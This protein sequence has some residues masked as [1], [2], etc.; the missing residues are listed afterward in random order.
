[1]SS[2]LAQHIKNTPLADTHEHLRSEQE[3]VENSPDILQSL[4]DNYVASD[5]AVA[6]A[7]IAAVHALIDGSDPDLR[8]RFAGVEAAWP[9]VAHTGFGEA[10]R[11]AARELYDIEEINIDTL[12]AAQPR[13]KFLCRPGQR[14]RLLRERANLD[15]VQIDDFT[16]ACL[17]DISGPDF[18]LFDISWNELCKGLPDVQL[19]AG[20]TGIE[21]RD[22]ASLQAVMESI[23]DQHAAI[24]VAVKA[25]HAYERTLS[26]Q[27]R[28]EE[29]AAEALA[30]YLCDPGG[31]SE[32]VRLCLG[33]WCWARGVELAIE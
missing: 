32:A 19:L 23:F 2:D 26:W 27:E 16:V 7:P 21:I 10:V 12:E 5:L 25:Q 1:M 31:S 4:F 15:H 14:L 13:H 17:P 11:I 30:T 24:A 28:T 6:G 3:Y 29:E 9:A 33:D 8:S 20:E 18:F 22:I